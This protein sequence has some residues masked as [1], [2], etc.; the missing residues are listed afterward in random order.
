MV[1]TFPG[2]S[3]MTKFFPSIIFSFYLLFCK[4]SD[5]SGNFP[6]FLIKFVIQYT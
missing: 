5:I 6:N 4:V 2:D 3:T 1:F